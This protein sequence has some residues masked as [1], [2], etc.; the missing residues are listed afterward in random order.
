VGRRIGPNQ[1]SLDNSAIY[2]ASTRYGRWGHRPE[3]LGEPEYK[4]ERYQYRLD[5]FSGRGKNSYGGSSGFADALKL[6]REP[7]L[8]RKFFAKLQ[9]GTE[10]DTVDD[11][12]IR[13]HASNDFLLGSNSFADPSLVLPKHVYVSRYVPKAEKWALITHEGSESVAMRFGFPYQTAHARFG[14]TGEQEFRI[15]VPTNAGERAMRHRAEDII[16]QQTAR[17]RSMSSFG[18]TGLDADI[19]FG[20]LDFGFNLDLGDL[21]GLVGRR[22]RRFL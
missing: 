3:L 10:V 18:S 11:A 16:A 1:H 2:T 8:K 22:R 7:G 20:E 14:N 12:W 13:S 19:G 5:D 17:A 15:S 9:N 21:S 4:P 6:A